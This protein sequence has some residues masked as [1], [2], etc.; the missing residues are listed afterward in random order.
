M[1]AKKAWACSLKQI[2]WKS[3]GFGGAS[4]EFLAYRNGF[5]YGGHRAS[6]D[7]HALLE[8]L[9]CNLPESGDK[10]LK[11]L[12]ANARAKEIKVWALNAPF[13]NKDKLKARGYRWAAER[14]TWTGFVLNDNL[15][16]EVEWLR[17]QVYQGRTFNLE[18]EKTDALNRFTS[19]RGA[20]ETR[21][22]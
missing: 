10:A 14:K 18:L 11:V 21:N 12:L 15:P 19:R 20:T 3:E 4:L 7:C 8:L 17:E 2:P 1:F 22:Y 6:V 9:Q 5:H 13:D 16:Q